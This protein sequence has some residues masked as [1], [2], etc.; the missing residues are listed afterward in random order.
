[1]YNIN[2]D[3]SDG[4]SLSWLYDHGEVVERK[5]EGTGIYLKVLLDTPNWARFERR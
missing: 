1:M 2:I 5:D 4:A 3:S